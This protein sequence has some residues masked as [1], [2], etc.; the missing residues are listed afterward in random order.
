MSSSAYSRKTLKLSQQ[1]GQHIPTFV[2]L[3]LLLMKICISYQYVKPNFDHW[4][5]MLRVVENVDKYSKLLPLNTI[6]ELPPPFER[7]IDLLRNYQNPPYIVFFDQSNYDV[8]LNFI[9][10]LQYFDVK[11]RLVAISFDALAE[12]ALNEAYPE[13]TTV[14]VDF[15]YVSSLL[16]TDLE[17]RNYLIYQLILLLRSRISAALAR[18][19]IDFW[20][21]QQDSLWINNVA[22]LNLEDMYSNSYMMFDIVG[23][24]HIPIY[25]RMKGWICGS[26]YFVRG[27]DI[28]ADFFDKVA[29]FMT[30][31]LSPD[32]AIMTYLCGRKYYKCAKLPRRIASSSDYF[33]G[34]RNFLPAMLQIDHRSKISKM[35]LFRA[36]NFNFLLNDGSCNYT[37]VQKL[38]HTVPIA[39]REVRLQQF[40]ENNKLEDI[41][42]FFKENFGLDPFNNRRF[43]HV[44]DTLV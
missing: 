32:S 29:L 5:R 4:R 26:T 2:L 19:K 31:R 43:L 9:C 33:L 20:A 42:Y 6:D 17:N 28:T 40:E 14:T 44:H 37:A 13:I 18:N 15:T 1:R 41:F 35:D 39:L 22:N 30:R 34:S 8:T 11:E 3:A 21:V 24:D 10:N 27:N 25:E 7:F 38:R 12:K 16:S 23:N 36:N